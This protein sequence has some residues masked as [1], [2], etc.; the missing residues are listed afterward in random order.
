MGIELYD[1]PRTDPRTG[2]RR[3]RF[4]SRKLPSEYVNR[5]LRN[6]TPTEGRFTRILGA[7]WSSDSV[8]TRHSSF[9]DKEAR[10][11]P[12]QKPELIARVSRALFG[13]R[14]QWTS[15]IVADQP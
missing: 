7:V 12:P 4:E 2:G 5:V 15:R 10:V 11:Q 13:L 1:R 9:F 6:Y 14:F 3:E 8:P